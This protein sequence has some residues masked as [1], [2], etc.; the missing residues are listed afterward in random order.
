MAFTGL[1]VFLAIPLATIA[2]VGEVWASGIAGARRLTAI[3][4]APTAVAEPAQPLSSGAVTAPELVLDDVV[5]PALAGLSLTVR[6][7]E[8]VGLAT[9]DPAA[10]GAL[11]D[12][13]ARRTDPVSGE[14]RVDG[15]P[16]SRIALDA[17]RA[18]VTVESGHAPWV[19]EA[20]LAAN[21]ALRHPD[22]PEERAAHALRAAA[23]DDLLA[24]PEG[25]ATEVG[26]RG[27][28]LS[29]GQRQRVAAARALAADAPVLVLEDPTSA[30]D[31]LTE[32]VLAERLADA[33][34][35]RTTLLLTVSPTLLSRC[36]RVLLVE[37]GTVVAEGT[38]AGLLS[39]PRYA[40]L[41][42]DAA[43]TAP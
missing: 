32:T 12:L 43:E 10:T 41:F 37:A 2:E 28:M 4:N 5:H 35:G 11:C 20:S 30:L 33:R 24:R 14:I 27:L 19:A 34:R 25:L 42:A 15:R 13:L 8:L 22:L 7:A 16:L 40:A 17:V 6:G 3:L 1:A 18:T 31:T 23:G 26:E 29:G 39:D 38:H 36:D 21:V 9:A